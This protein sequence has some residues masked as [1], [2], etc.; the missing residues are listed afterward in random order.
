MRCAC[1]LGIGS[2]SYWTYGVPAKKCPRCL[3]QRSEPMPRVLTPRCAIA[4]LPRTTMR[5][6]VSFLPHLD[7]PRQWRELRSFTLEQDSCS[8]AYAARARS[9]MPWLMLAR[10]KLQS[11]WQAP[12]ASWPLSWSRSSSRLERRDRWALTS[13]LVVCAA[14]ACRQGLQKRAPHHGLST[15]LG[16]LRSAALV[17]TYN[18]SAVHRGPIGDG[19]GE[20]P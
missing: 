8:D 11:I 3:A 15:S 1:T 5:S 4:I 14:G 18:S 20:P 6:V 19:P 12:Q 7:R 2:Y 9:D 13:H 10:A 16:P 17:S